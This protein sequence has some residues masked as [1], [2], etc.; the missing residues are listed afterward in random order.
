LST[1]TW[2]RREGARIIRAIAAKDVVD[3]VRNKTLQGIAIGVLLLVLSGRALPLLASRSSSHAV[4]VYDE[5]QSRLVAALQ[6][7]DELRVSKARSLQEM[8]DAVSG[9]SV[10]VL[11]LHLP[12]GLDQA[13]EEGKPPLLQA[14]AVHWAGQ[15]D[16]AEIERAVER[17]LGEVAGQPVEISVAGQP[18]YPD[19]ESSQFTGLVAGLIVM[20]VAVIGM[21]FVPYLVVEEKETRTLQALLVSPASIGQ[22][23][24]GKALAGAVYCLAGGGAAIALNSLYVVHWEAVLLSILCGTALAVALGLLLGVLFG[25]PQQASAAGALLMG[26]L[27]VATFVADMADLPAALLAV[28]RWVPTVAMAHAL[29]LSFAERAP[30]GWLAADLGAVLAAAAVVY[31][32]VAWRIARMD[33]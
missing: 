15:K 19:P 22:V 16:V 2:H 10:A 11:G 6:K 5:G 7:R 12:A 20:V 8:K 26:V 28:L 13:L 17:A 33:R 30:A 18:L 32:L 1:R 25:L 29:R 9:A 23:V 24:A 31:A 27:V 4:I 3:A 21:A 14:T